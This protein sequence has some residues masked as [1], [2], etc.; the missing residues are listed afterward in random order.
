M[1]ILFVPLALGATI[2]YH[3]HRGWVHR[4]N[5]MYIEGYGWYCKECVGE[6]FFAWDECNE[7]HKIDEN[8]FY[9]LSLDKWIC[10]DCGEKL[11]LHLYKSVNLVHNCWYTGEELEHIKKMEAK[12]EEA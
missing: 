12:K 5:S 9:C 6:L 10:K 11:G 7:L 4:E 2:E 1:A 3:V 8:I